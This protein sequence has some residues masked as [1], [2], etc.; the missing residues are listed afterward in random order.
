[1]G[2]LV[3]RSDTETGGLFFYKLAFIVKSKVI[4]LISLKKLSAPCSIR[5]ATLILYKQFGVMPQFR[6]AGG[7]Y[8]RSS[9]DLYEPRPHGG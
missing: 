9:R 6:A 3:D 8:E 7:T 5:G 4:D 2:V 1:M